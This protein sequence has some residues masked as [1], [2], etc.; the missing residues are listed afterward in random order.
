MFAFI[1][2]ILISATPS[3]VVLEVQGIGYVLF[4]PCSAFGGLPVIGTDVLLYTTLVIREF[5]QALYGFLTLEERDIFEVFMNVSGIGPKLA[6]SLIGHLPLNQLQAAIDQKDLSA[7]CKV[8]GVG[9]KTAERL[10]VELRDKLSVFKSFSGQI[11]LE[12]SQ[13][14]SHH[15]RISDAMMAL[16]NLGY[17]Q[18][19]AQKAIKQSLKNLPE[20]VDLA[21]LITHALKNT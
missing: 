10:F 4:I 6:L 2:G 14:D 13:L 20:E 12:H 11:T 7:L 18:S 15:Q 5:S 3:Q 16:I 8:P 17:N 1:K 21:T 9:K 19:I